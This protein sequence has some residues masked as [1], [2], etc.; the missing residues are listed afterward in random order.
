M[1][2]SNLED[3]KKHLAS[4]KKDGDFFNTV[5]FNGFKIQFVIGAAWSEPYHEFDSPLYYKSLGILI[6]EDIRDEKHQVAPSTDSRFQNFDWA[7]YFYYTNGHGK[8]K[9]SYMG[10]KIPLAE[11]IQLVRDIYKVSRLSV[12]Y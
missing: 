5:S 7:K 8:I 11:S 9:A 6:Y 1:D 12:F 10:S 2:F 4:L 3:I